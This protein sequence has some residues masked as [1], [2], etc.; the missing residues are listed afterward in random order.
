MCFQERPQTGARV[1]RIKRKNG[2]LV[3]N[4]DVYI[5]HRMDN[6]HWNLQRSKWANPFKK[7]DPQHLHN[8]ADHI[9][10]KLWHDLDSLEG[11]LLGCWCDNVDHCHGRVL[12][13]LLEEKKIK[14]LNNDFKKR[15]LR[16]DLS[17][18]S[19]IRR[20]HDWALEPHFLA[21]ATRLDRTSIFYFQPEVYMAVETVW[22]IDVPKFWPAYT[23]DNNVFWVVGLYRG[24]QPIGPFW[25][26]EAD[27]GRLLESPLVYN[28]QMPHVCDV[29]RFAKDIQPYVDTPRFAHAIDEAMRYHTLHRCIVRRVGQITDVD[30]ADHDLTKSRIVQVALA[31]AWHWDDE[32]RDDKLLDAA[33]LAIV[34][35][36][37]E[38]ENH[39]PE[40]ADVGFGEVH[41]EK[42]LVDR[43]SAHLQKDKVDNENG[44]GLLP[45]WIPFPLTE[46]WEQF[47]SAKKHKNLYEECLW[48]AKN[49]ITREDDVV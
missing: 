17:D 11:K 44:W 23:N 49:E 13:D 5:A 19:Q 41:S 16:T 12:V 8:Y 40:Y 4:C 9:R 32:S 48:K 38:C 46:Q 10:K 14:D 37:N 24:R 2:V 22:G 20:S 15:G 1:V 43:L 34:G 27:F 42:L 3:Q 29:F 26:E 7:S 30:M 33:K 18:L 31:Y 6:D 21:Y 36:H 45:K 25:D 35:G 39:H 28:P 47:K